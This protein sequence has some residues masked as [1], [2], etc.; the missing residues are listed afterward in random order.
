MQGSR[1]TL[2]LSER[3]ASS[4]SGITYYYVCTMYVHSMNI[5]GA[6]RVGGGSCAGVALGW[7][8]CWTVRRM[9]DGSRRKGD[10][11]RMARARWRME[12]KLLLL[13]GCSNPNPRSSKPPTQ[14]GSAPCQL[15]G[16]STPPQGPGAAA[17]RACPCWPTLASR[18]SPRAPLSPD[19]AL[20]GEQ[21]TNAQPS[22]PPAHDAAK[23]RIQALSQGLD[24]D[25]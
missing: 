3:R 17:V 2:Q 4:A 23:A 1:L 8:D 21:E 7:M 11:W 15:V 20:H 16:L 12:S 25:D 13:P 6:S 19:H 22:P 9:G 24:D 14:L 5:L 18:S 10:G